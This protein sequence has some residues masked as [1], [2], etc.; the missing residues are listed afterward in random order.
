MCKRKDSFSLY[1]FQVEIIDAVVDHILKYTNVAIQSIL[2][3]RVRV[4]AILTLIVRE[5]LYADGIIVIA[6]SFHP[7]KQ[8]AANMVCY[9]SYYW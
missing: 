7:A 9:K 6:Q 3:K 5:T 1:T 8:T 2:V 4:T